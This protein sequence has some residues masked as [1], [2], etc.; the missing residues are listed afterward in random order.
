MSLHR[1][2]N[3]SQ[4][5][6]TSAGFCDVIR[7]AI[8]ASTCR[9]RLRPSS[10]QTKSTARAWYPAHC[11]RRYRRSYANNEETRE[12]NKPSAY[13]IDHRGYCSAVVDRKAWP[14]CLRLMQGNDRLQD[15]LYHQERC[16]LSTC[17]QVPLLHINDV[18]SPSAPNIEVCT[19]AIYP[20]SRL[21]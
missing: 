21:A 15:A 10:D 19:K 8:A 5:S 2:P 18:F 1:T 16:N 9:L 4:A 17:R 14:Q 3:V 6:S 7:C 11:S 12:C 20:V 13:G